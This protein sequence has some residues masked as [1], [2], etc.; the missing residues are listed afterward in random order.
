MTIFACWSSLSLL[1]LHG[2]IGVA[3]VCFVEEAKLGTRHQ[4]PS[5]VSPSLCVVVIG[6]WDKEFEKCVV[7]T[8]VEDWE[9]EEK[10]GDVLF[11]IRRIYHLNARCLMNCINLPYMLMVWNW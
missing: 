6:V 11:Y 9:F 10:G 5:L 2:L 7:V 4:L 3:W 8:S 1:R